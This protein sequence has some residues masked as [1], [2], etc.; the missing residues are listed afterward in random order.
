MS[1]FHGNPGFRI[2]IFWKTSIFSYM[3]SFFHGNQG[4]SFLALKFIILK[5]WHVLFSRESGIQNIFFEDFIFSYM[6]CLFHGNTGFR[7]F[8]EEFTFLY[9]VCFFQGNQG[10]S[11]LALKF[12]ILKVWH[13]LFSRKSGIQNLFFWRL[14]FFLYG[15][16]FSR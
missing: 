6:V 13:V 4:F 14:L 12:I 7:F 1:Y 15:V 3:V 11:F 10:F 16:F 5:V 8:L 9:M 2:F